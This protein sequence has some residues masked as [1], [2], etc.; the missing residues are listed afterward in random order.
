MNTFLTRKTFIG[1][2]LALGLLGAMQTSVALAAGNH[3]GS[4]PLART[5]SS[6]LMPS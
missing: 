1:G 3:E 6:K 5:L 2:A 4:P